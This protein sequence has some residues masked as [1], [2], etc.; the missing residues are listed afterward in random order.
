MNC[1]T[2]LNKCWSCL[3]ADCEEHPIRYMPS[4]EHITNI[5]RAGIELGRQKHPEH[6]CTSL[7]KWVQDIKEELQEAQEELTKFLAQPGQVSPLRLFDETLD[8]AIVIFRGLKYLSGML[9]KE[10]AEAR[11]GDDKG[12]DDANDDKNAYI[13]HDP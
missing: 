10:T 8:S 1:N 11:A 13:W 4:D 12:V 6:E 2:E 9:A 7:L 3:D 5:L